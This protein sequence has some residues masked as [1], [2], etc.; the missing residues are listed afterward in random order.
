M[1]TRVQRCSRAAATSAATPVALTVQ[2]VWPA[3]RGLGRVHLGVSRGVD[4]DGVRGEV[5]VGQRLRV[6]QVE[7]VP[8]HGDRVG[9]C[10][11][12][13]P[14]QLTVR[15]DDQ[16]RAGRH[17]GDIGQSR[18]GL[19]GV[20]QLGLVERDR[21]VD[22]QG[23]VGQ[24]DERIGLLGRRAPM[25][26][27]QVG[28][29][30]LVLEGLERVAD[31]AGHEDRGLRPHLEGARTGRNDHPAEGQP[32]P[33]RSGPSPARRACPRAQRGCPGSLRRGC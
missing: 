24:V 18:M 7:L 4:H 2:A 32:R 10:L 29:R 28:V 16:G 9:Q 31:A 3:L 6:G 30:G 25:V 26:V 20:G 1:C 8:A 5:E 11:G 12:Q 19:V 33:R 21:P 22:R 27:D 14:A 17:R 13:S 15:P 23:L